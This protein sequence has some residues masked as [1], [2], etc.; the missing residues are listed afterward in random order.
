MI[1]I[2]KGIGEQHP[3]PS[4]RM[5]LH[6]FGLWCP[7]PFRWHD[8]LSGVAGKDGRRHHTGQS[9]TGLPVQRERSQSDDGSNLHE[10]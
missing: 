3:V 5:G 7:T 10:L 4:A 1:T 2:G 9:I 6:L 8:P